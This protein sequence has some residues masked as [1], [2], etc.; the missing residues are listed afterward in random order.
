MAINVVSG[1]YN[2]ELLPDIIL[3]NFSGSLIYLVLGEL[4]TT[5]IC[6]FALS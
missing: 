4:V 6:F 2:R 5:E 1:Q 3:L